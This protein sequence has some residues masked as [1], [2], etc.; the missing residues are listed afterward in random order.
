MEVMLWEGCKYYYKKV[1]NE[2]TGSINVD[3]TLQESSNLEIIII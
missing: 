1:S 3:Q 2:W